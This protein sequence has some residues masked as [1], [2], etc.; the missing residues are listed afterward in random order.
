M[1]EVVRG[2]KAPSS[3]SAH[4]R[5]VLGLKR[6]SPMARN[7]MAVMAAIQELASQLTHEQLPNA[8]TRIGVGQDLIIADVMKKI[9]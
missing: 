3:V 9:L 4:V 2:R 1:S 7:G 5:N 6:V 8:P